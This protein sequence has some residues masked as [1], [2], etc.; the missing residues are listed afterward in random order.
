MRGTLLFMAPVTPPRVASPLM[1]GREPELNALVELVHAPRSSAA[2]VALVG[3]RAGMGKTRLVAEAS[4]R[5]RE[6]G[7]RVLIGY[8]A[9]VEGTP[10]APL[11][12]SMRAALPSNAPL[13]GMLRS[14]RA[15]SRSELFDALG[16]A[17]AGLSARAPLILVIEDLHWSDRATRDALTYILTQ[18]FGGRWGMVGTYRYEGPLSPAELGSLVDAVS[19]G[20][21]VTRVTL[22]PLTPAQVGDLAAMI[23]GRRLAEPEAE[24]LHRRTGGIPLLVEEVLALR[25]AGLPDHLRSMFV[26]R[27]AEQGTEVIAALQVVAVAEHCDEM[28]VADALEVE[29]PRVS[30]ALRRARD[31]DLVV[32]DAQAYRFRHDLLRE[33]VYDEIPPGRRRELHRRVAEQLTMRAAVDAAVLAGHWHLAGERDNA[34]AGEHGRGRAGGTGARAR[35]R[36]TQHYERVLVA[37][38]QLGEPHPAEVR[39][40]RRAAP[41]GGLRIGALRRVRSS[42]GPR[43]RN[44]SPRD[45]ARR[46][47]RRFAGSGWVATGGRRGTAT[48]RAP[49]TSRRCGCYRVDAPAAAR[50]TVLSGL[51]WHLAQSFHFEEARPLAAEALAACAGVDD[52]AV[53]W[54][55]H[56]ARGNRVA[57]HR[58]PGTRR[59]RNRVAW[60]PRSGSGNAWCS[61]GCGSTSAT[62][63]CGQDR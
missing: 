56:L 30:D 35:P 51:A 32:V 62:S 44:A 24:S 9:P 54:Q 59:W 26:T 25:H 53:R 34:A 49:R 27:V 28:L 46:R 52:P 22:E 60:P 23:T 41:P 40:A 21:P 57:R 8:C 18:P 12:A 48:A 42:R 45:A 11:V 55:A 38:P 37:W 17:L 4:R 6:E 33:A 19:R 58:A 50:A 1:I 39:S 13:L 63:G 36:R 16:S 31:A 5:W 10:Y 29:A 43:R 2:A 7:V 15:A 20:G 47:I 14:A 3:G 61:V